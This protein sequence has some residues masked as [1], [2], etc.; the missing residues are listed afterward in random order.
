MFR[1]QWVCPVQG[2]LCFPHPHCSGSRLLHMEW[3]QLLS[4]A[5]AFGSSTKARIRLRLRLV[6]SPPQRFR[7]PEACAPSPR[8]RRAFSLRAEQLRQPEAW[9]HLPE[10]RRVFSLRREQ[11]R[12]PEAWAPSPRAR[13][14]FSHGGAPVG[15]QEVFRQEPGPVC[16]VGGGGFSGAEFARFRSPCLLPPAGMG[17]LFSGVS[18][19]LCFA[20]PQLLYPF[21]C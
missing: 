20:V 8:M 7:Q 1:P 10:M 6:S 18:Q 3:A 11:L 14:A 9:A 12:Q 15:S 13:R 2:C 19:S 21:T 17:W 16:R 5:P 4:A